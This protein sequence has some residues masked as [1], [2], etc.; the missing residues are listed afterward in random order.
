VNVVET[1]ARAAWA[2]TADE[3]KAQSRIDGADEDLYLAALIQRVQEDLEA[4]CDRAFSDR[5]LR[6]TM[7]AFPARILLPFAP[8]KEVTSIAYVDADGVTQTLASTAYTL[9]A[10][11]EPAVIV[12]AYG[13][14]WPSTRPVPKAVTV[15]YTAGGWGTARPLP[16]AYKDAI[17]ATVAFRFENREDSGFPAAVIDNLVNLRV[18][19]SYGGQ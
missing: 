4:E 3:V 2:V 6:L 15:L 8:A 1:A 13:T 11:A 19:A 7:A 14:S 12:P 9:D 5:T 17:L 18:W 16:N 10:D